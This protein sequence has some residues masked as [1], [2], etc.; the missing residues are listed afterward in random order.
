[1]GATRED[2]E[3]EL[4]AIRGSSVESKVAA[5]LRINP[6][7]DKTGRDFSLLVLKFECPGQG[8]GEVNDHTTRCAAQLAGPVHPS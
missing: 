7:L 8:K 3:K 2:R 1:M 5:S 6:E 4:E